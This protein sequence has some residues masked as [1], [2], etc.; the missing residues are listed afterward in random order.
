MDQAALNAFIRKIVPLYGHMDVTTGVDG[1]RFFAEV[2]RTD[3]LMAHEGTIHPAFQWAAGE[4]LGGTVT[5]HVFDGLSGLFLVVKKVDIE[6]VRPARRD[7]VAECVFDQAAQDKLK[8]DVAAGEGTFTLD[9]TLK[10]SQGTT[11]ATMVGHY[12]VRPRRS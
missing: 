4:L 2:P 6:F 12:L 7:I 3:A 8:A 10:D 5:L 9:V 11:V 1:D